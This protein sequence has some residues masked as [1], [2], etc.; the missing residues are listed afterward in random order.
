MTKSSKPSKSKV[1][2]NAKKT[3]A[4]RDVRHWVKHQSQQCLRCKYGKRVGVWKKITY[5]EELQES[6]LQGQKDKD[7]NWLLGCSAC[8]LN[9]V[10]T[11]FGKHR[12]A[13][14]SKAALRQHSAK[15]LHQESVAKKIGIPFKRK[16]APPREHWK[17][18]LEAIVDGRSYR[19]GVKQIGT[20]NKMAKMV[21]C[22]AECLRDADRQFMKRLASLT[23]IRDES[24]AKLVIRFIASDVEANVKRGHAAVVSDFGTGA[25]NIV[26]AFRTAFKDMFTPGLGA[27]GHQKGQAKAKGIFMAEAHKSALAKVEFLVS[28]AASDELLAGKFARFGSKAEGVEPVFPNIKHLAWDKAH[29]A[30]RPHF[31]TFFQHV[32]VA[33]CSILGDLPTTES[34]KFKHS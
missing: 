33:V 16:L 13:K 4:D 14:L 6:W 31:S 21:W 22:L 34:T 26:E 20:Q 24:K 18:V 30:R 25:A 12:V 17:Q 3:L 29:G 5:M 11:V 7:G 8:A 27:P 9:N 32:I 2:R 10:D 1:R 28:D 19:K 23:V 15:S